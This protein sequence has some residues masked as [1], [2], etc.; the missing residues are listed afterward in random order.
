MI[1]PKIVCLTIFNNNDHYN[2]YYNEMKEHNEYYIKF[3][4]NNAVFSKNLTVLYIIY[5]NLDK[6]DYLVE[7][8]LLYING[9]ETYMPGILDKTLLAMEIVTNKL[10][11]EYDFILRTNASTVI[12]YFELYDYLKNCDINVNEHYYYIGTYYNLTWYDYKNGIIDDTYHGTRFCSGTF[13]MIN[14]LL[15][16]NIINNNDKI[17]RN[18]IDD[19]SIGQYVNTVKNVKEI[20]IRDL[21]LFRC[22]EYSTDKKYISY[23]NNTNKED[24]IVDVINFKCQINSI[25][26]N[27]KKL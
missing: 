19:V 16:I 27:R 13:T 7:G 26:E 25:I 15:T 21:A 3:L 9:D 5:K 17:L 10:N 12:D 14:R 6:L 11:I 1:D 23:L 20:D 2:C 18:L 24:R 4:N 8:N 22:E